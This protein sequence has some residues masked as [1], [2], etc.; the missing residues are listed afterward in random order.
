MSLR[1]AGCRQAEPVRKAVLLLLLVIAL[2]LQAGEWGSRGVSRR[3][4]V[5]GD[6]LYAADGRG[7]TV[8]DVSNAASLRRIDVETGDDETHDLA[9]LGSNRLVVGTARGIDRFEVASD[10][11]L[12]RLDSFRGIR[13]VTRV[14]ANDQ[15][16]AAASGSTVMILTDDATRFYRSIQLGQRVRALMFIGGLLYVGVEGVA[17]YVY[18]PLTAAQVAV[19]SHDPSDFA[20]NG[21]ILWS[22]GAHGL[23]AIDVSDPAAP[24]LVGQVADLILTNVAAAG[25][26]VY[27]VESKDLLHVFDGSSPQQPHLVS[28]VHEWVHVVAASGS[29]VFTSGSQFDEEGLIYETG[30]PVRVYDAANMT[31]VSEFTDYAG[32]VSGAWTDGSVAFIVDPPYLRVL[33]VSRSAEPREMTSILVPHIQDHI[34]VRNGFAIIYGRSDVNLIDV[35]D[36]WKPKYLSTY[37]A[38]GHPPGAAALLRDTFV[39]ANEHSGLHIV[40]YS[41]PANAVQIAGRIWHYHDVAAG[42]DAV[43][44]MAMGQFLILDITDRTKVVDR[45]IESFESKAQIDTIPPSSGSPQYVVIRG[46]SGLYFRGLMED[47]FDPSLVA[48]VPIA[49]AGVFGSFDSGVYVT[50]DGALWRIN[51]S[52]PSTLIETGLRVTSPQQIAVAGEKIVVADRYSVRVYGPD[53]AQPPQPPPTPPSRRRATRH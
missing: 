15:I 21:S 27:A 6:R 5:N 51:V 29:R 18:D 43:Y 39:Q 17:I 3:F 11:S 9:L 28:T 53:T 25:S 8:Y 50:I 37:E 24:H 4:V 26:R 42:D 38:K 14:A 33:D 20:R 32:P 45:K 22:A 30:V 7:V 46:L 41:D 52:D 23:A 16:V 47:R 19:V 2:P 48:M 34:R 40:D 36:P 13:D 49:N 10:G 1:R 12:T 44:V 35:S 31:V